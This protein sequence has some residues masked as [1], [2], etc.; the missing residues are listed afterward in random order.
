MPKVL[1]MFYFF[2]HLLQLHFPFGTL[3][4]T[5]NYNLSARRCSLPFAVCGRASTS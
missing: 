4:D 5:Q 3:V 2:E 1:F